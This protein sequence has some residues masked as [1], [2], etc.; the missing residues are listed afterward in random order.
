MNLSTTSSVSSTSCSNSIADSSITS[1]AAKIGAETR[2]ASARASEGRESIS[3]S[4]PLTE[5]SLLPQ[6]AD[7]AGI[8][9]DQ[10]IERI[11]KAAHS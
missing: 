6:A 3:S 10:L 5:T 11:L 2:T 9:F 1:S 8:G 7:A 4:E